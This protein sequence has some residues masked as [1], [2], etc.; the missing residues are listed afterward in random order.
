MTRVT[1]HKIDDK[2]IITDFQFGKD[3]SPEQS[4][5]EVLSAVIEFAKLNAAACNKIEPDSITWPDVLDKM[6]SDLQFARNTI[7][8]RL[9]DGTLSDKY[10][11]DDL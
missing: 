11:K 4:Y 3:T 1:A 2:H 5:R 8:R 6:V 7:A 10:W 9:E